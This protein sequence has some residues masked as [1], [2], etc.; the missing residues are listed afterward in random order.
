MTFWHTS[1]FLILIIN[2]CPLCKITFTLGVVYH[3]TVGA[4]MGISKVTFPLFTAQSTDLSHSKDPTAED[5]LASVKP[6]EVKN[7]VNKVADEVLGNFQVGVITSALCDI[8]VSHLCD[9]PVS[10]LCDIPVS[11]LRDIPVTPM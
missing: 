1:A 3:R 5:I 8:P 11:Y 7:I 10:H 2:F 9:I 4:C 6:V